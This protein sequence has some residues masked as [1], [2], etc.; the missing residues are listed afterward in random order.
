MGRNSIKPA[1]SSFPCSPKIARNSASTF[2]ALAL[3]R[4][5]S[6]KDLSLIQSTSN[7]ANSWPKSSAWDAVAAKI[8]RF[9]SAST[10]KM[11]PGGAN[12]SSVS[13][14]AAAEAKR[15]GNTYRPNPRSIGIGGAPWRRMGGDVT[16]SA[17]GTTL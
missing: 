6:P 15:S 12:G 2:S 1:P 17:I 13:I 11:P 16:A 3:A 7:K 14:K 8:K 4:G 10:R 5:N 9:L